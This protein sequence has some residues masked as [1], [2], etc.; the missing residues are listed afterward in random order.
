MVILG[1]DSQ[2]WRMKNTIRVDVRQGIPHT[3]NGDGIPIMDLVSYI[4]AEAARAGVDSVVVSASREEKV[5]G[6]V[7]VI[8]ECRK[9]RVK[10]IVLN[11]YLDALTNK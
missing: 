8:D 10:V 6:V 4:N 5:G 11:E 1:H 2:H 7:T 3:R 9:T